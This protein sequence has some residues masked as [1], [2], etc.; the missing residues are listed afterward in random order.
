MWRYRQRD[1]ISKAAGLL[2]AGMA[3]YPLL[4]LAIRKARPFILFCVANSC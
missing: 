2:M 1:M 4:V 3:L